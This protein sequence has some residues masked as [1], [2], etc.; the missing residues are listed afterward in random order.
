MG[1]GGLSSP[2]FWEGSG[3]EGAAGEGWGGVGKG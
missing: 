3:G 1:E 2:L